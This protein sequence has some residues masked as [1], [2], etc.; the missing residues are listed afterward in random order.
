MSLDRKL[1]KGALFMVA[2]RWAS[3]AL[4]L[5]SAM[6]MARL[7]TPA[8]FGLVAVALAAVG[9]LELVFE[10]STE[11]SLISRNSRDRDEWNTAWSLRVLAG[12]LVT[13]G[14]AVAGVVASR[15][16]G[17]ARYGWIF[18]AVALCSLIR[19][20]E[21]IGLIGFRLDLQF[22]R[23]AR[24]LMVSKVASVT[25]SIVFAWIFRNYYAILGAMLAS[26]AF[27][28]AY[29]FRVH[30]YRPSFDLSKWGVFL[31]FSWW[32]LVLNLGKYVLGALDKI[33]LAK[34]IP[35]SALGSY[36]MSGDLASLPVSEVVLPISRTLNVGFA[37]VRDEPDRLGRL[38]LKAFS[39]VSLVAFPFTVG[40]AL[41]ANEL[42]LVVL[43]PQWRSAAP[44]LVIF[45]FYF[46][47]MSLSHYFGT[48]LIVLDRVKVQAAVTCLCAFLA[49]AAGLWFSKTIDPALAF[50]L[51]RTT[52]AFALAL[53][54][55][56]IQV[57]AGS[58]TLA[59]LVGQMWRPAFASAVMAA[60]V[61]AIDWQV[62][63]A[64]ARLLGKAAVGAAVFT[65]VVLGAWWMAGRPP[66][67]ESAVLEIVTVR[68]RAFR[69]RRQGGRSARRVP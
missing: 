10:S 54:L 42:V 49:I 29:S 66:A 7:L 67:A 19:G 57:A 24:Y 61:L 3:R 11:T 6:V 50:A 16:Y 9:L 35:P 4:G 51:A 47:F 64:L 58:I 21:N 34:L 59:A 52:A 41:T 46:L 1:A 53:W 40:M 38:L 37:S 30:P 27:Q 62:S 44:F 13:L 63:S 69:S 36:K 23:D 33:L 43:G 5:V 32:M 2:L 20:F 55:W 14:M 39:L 60:A 65:V 15:L 45:S 25:A 56:G 31:G 12:V 68:L 26:S 28:V 22:D 17:D 18:V 8:D 48:A